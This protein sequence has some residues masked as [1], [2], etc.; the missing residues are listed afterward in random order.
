MAEGGRRSGEAVVALQ[1]NEDLEAALARDRNYIG[2]R[3]VEVVP[4]TWAEF[5]EIMTKMTPSDNE[6]VVRL[7][8]LPY[9]ATI[10]DIKAF[11]E[12][13][14]PIENGILVVTDDQGRC[15]GEAYVEFA[16]AESAQ[17]ALLR[18]R[19]KMGTR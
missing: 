15:G 5:T 12:G 16:D 17:K 1:T 3:W 8:G 9:A 11:F 2:K 14:E 4:S 6:F 13:L 7:R 19:N 10:E 18:H